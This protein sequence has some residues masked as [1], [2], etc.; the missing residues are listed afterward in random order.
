MKL[1]PHR[2]TSRLGLTSAACVLLFLTFARAQQPAGSPA[3]PPAA[4]APAAVPVAPP[5]P[6][7]AIVAPVEP[8]APTPP[9]PKLLKQLEAI[10]TQKFSRDSADIFRALERSGTADTS[11]LNQP[12][13]FFTYFRTGDWGKIRE[14]L[15]QMPP[16]LARR[17]Y[18]K[19]LA[20]LTEKQK[21]NMRLDDVL[22]L[23]DA[24]P[25][26]LTN[27][28]LHKL[29]Q[30]LGLAVPANESYWLADRLKK[31]SEKL[32]GS[33]P[34]KR[35]LA[36]RV[37][38]AGNFKDLARTYLPPLDQVEKITDE[39]LRNEL[40]SFLTS[41]RES[42]SAQREQVQKV[43]DENLQ[44]LR[45]AKVADWERAKAGQALARV[46]TQI[47]QSTLA[48]VFSE[49][50]KTN[51]ENAIGL[52]SGLGRKLEAR[53]DVPVRTENLKALASVANLLA[54]N[55][56]LGTQPWNQLSQMMAEAWIVEAENTFT[57][58]TA[59]ADKSKFVAPEELLATAPAGKW[60]AA[61]PAGV[62]ERIDV[63][64]SKVI[65][66]S[67]NFDQAAD[68]IVEIGKRSPGAGVALAEDFL[69][70]WAKAHNPQIPEALRKKYELPDDARIP[71]TPIMME[72]NIES[73]ARMMAL[74]R[75]AGIAPKD[76][77][78]VVGAFDLA[79]SNAEAY[80]TSHIEKVFGPLDKMDESLFFLILSRM[81][82]NLSERWRKMDVQKA[83]LTR[84]DETQTLEMVRAGY[85]GALSMIEGW[86][87]GHAESSSRALTLAGT[88]LADWGDFEYFQELV[89]GDARK[90]MIGYK[91]KNLQ[92]QEYF[93]RGAEAY[94]KEVPKLA[95]ADYSVE[96]YLGWF[97]GLLGIGSGG[98]LNLSKA[99]NR[100]ALT[101]IREH[102]LALPGKAAPAHL[103]QFAKVV[104][105]RLADEKDPLHEDLKYR[106]LASALVITKDDPFT[107]GAEKKVAYFDELLSEIR[108][109]TRVDGPNTVGRDQDFG[110]IVS[111]IHT[112]AMGRVAQFGQYLTNDPGVAPGKPKKGKTPLARKMREAQGPRDELELSFTETLAPFFDIKSITFSS[113]EVKPRPT[114]KPGWEETVLAYI[115]V[116]P[117][118]A[119]VDKIPPVE[120]E[121]KF[122]DLSG[123]VTIPAESAETGIKVGTGDVP[124]RP[125]RQIEIAQT[126][127]T[128]QFQINGA[129]PLEIKATASGLVPELDQLL[130]LEA[131]KKAIGVK[132]INPHEG[133]QVKEINTWGDQ[134]APRS[135]RLWTIAL[136]GDPIRAA[137]GPTDFQ[138]PPP[139]S[140][141][142]TV[143]YQTYDDMNLATLPQPSVKIG[144][145]GSSGGVATKPAS[146]LGLW[147]GVC[148]TIALLG[149]G[150]LF[151]FAKRRAGTEQGPLRAGDVFKMPRDV[152]G[153]AVVAL[154]RRLRTSPLVKLPEPQQQELQQD[155]QRV[156]QACFGGNGG[157]M[158]EA[159]LRG[160]AEKWLR[161]AC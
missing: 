63:S 92:A 107:L 133:L 141:E 95:P 58:K 52:I 38:L 34:A 42:E 79:Y 143:V 50:L 149:G 66:A 10:L 144:R 101:K 47:P 17:I 124:A 24:A 73:L 18:D 64:L 161:V 152:D 74:F 53:G 157:A 43:W 72:K 71:V 78:K 159:D 138:F 70:V 126:L 103:S 112:E 148:A 60:A 127:D 128:R 15:A 31:G 98:Q 105:A 49:M 130:D 139:K 55:V 125:A 131:L 25:G 116:R 35:L 102:L 145:T 89:T 14:E 123:P 91:E 7:P 108:L 93:Q 106:Y 54:E 85:T 77:E 109:Q 117:K 40:T 129:L 122:V 81:N 59:S 45:R 36:G 90:R 65:L 29:G 39:G 2:L 113:P 6:A 154:L 147:L 84:R 82:A 120:M 140:K 12:E 119:S 94:A 5:T 57:Q 136:D 96:A 62:R 26:E 32:G 48:P 16:D 44:I 56:D 146:H 150:L 135:E 111:V 114:T 134:V 20:D 156:Q 142:S 67:A 115:L 86:L 153:F 3:A 37:L 97:H 88:L 11:T 87:A 33:D 75:Q 110:I 28:E 9:D 99:M 61:L 76:Y 83:G 155:L 121:L 158:S 4:P 118:D 69:N 151:A 104:N 160:I 68:R 100:A 1:F 21:P 30:L 13:R 41:E 8:P 23:G 46:I 19:M 22:G 132:N 27:D 51:P 80:R 137:D